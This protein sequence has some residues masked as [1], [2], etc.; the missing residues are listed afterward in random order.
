[1]NAMASQRSSTRRDFL[2]GQAA[3]DALAEAIDQA[4]GPGALPAQPRD[5]YL[6]Q[7]GRRAMACQFEVFSNAGQYENATD[8]AIEALDLIDTLEAQLT[9]YRETSEVMDI[10]RGAGS[11]AIEVEPRLFELL[12]YACQLHAETDGAYDITSGPLS[13]VWGFFRRQGELPAPHALAE[14]LARVGSQHVELSMQGQTIRF[15]RPGMELNLGSIGKGYALDRAAEV[16]TAAGMSDFLWHGG[17]SSILARGSQGSQPGGGWLVSI[18]DPLRP[19]KTL[20]HVR[21][22]DRALGTSGCGTQFFR[23]EGRRYGHILDP[24]T[25]WPVEGMLSATAVAPTAAQADALATAFYVMGPDRTLEYC[26]RHPEIAAVLACPR[27]GQAG[28]QIVTEGFQADELQL[29][30][31]AAQQAPPDNEEP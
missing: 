2:S 31:Q 12:Q 8:A 9:V 16:L 3:A 26:G 28:L 4:A 18:S 7:F 17:R 10:N 11:E 22:R 24:R 23:H 19:G 15:R 1:M 14:A 29:D 20:A 27:P 30:P 21:L 25:G 6:V 13:K 5:T